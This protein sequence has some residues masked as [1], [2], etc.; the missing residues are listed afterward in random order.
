MLFHYAKYD[1]VECCVLFL[2][3]LNVVMLSVIM[4]SVAVPSSCLGYTFTQGAQYI[5]GENPKVVWAEFQL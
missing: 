2:V 5:M 3:M 4:L 1:H